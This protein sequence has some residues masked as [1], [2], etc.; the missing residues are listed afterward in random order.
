MVIF[1]RIFWV[2]VTVSLSGGLFYSA[3][4][5]QDIIDWWRLRDYKPSANIVQLS[6]NASFSDL[7][8][9]LFYVHDP[10]LLDKAQFAQSCTVGE[11]T[12]VLGCYITHQRIFVFDVDD[13]RLSGAEEVTAAHE[14][15]HAAYDRLSPDRS[16][17]IDELLIDTFNSLDDPGLKRVV[18]SYRDRDPS[19]VPNELHSILGTEVRDL[20]KLLEEHYAQ[21]FADRSVVVGLAEN[22]S[23]EFERREAEIGVL[24][25]QLE[26]LKSEIARIESDLTLQ[27][28]ALTRD[29]KTLESLVG[30]DP[31]E[32]NRRI[33]AF[34]SRINKYNSD[35]AKAGKLVDRH[36]EIV[37]AR[38]TI[39]LEEK[40]L[41]EAIDT[42]VEEL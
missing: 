36:N 40:E 4:H 27:A 26:S 1:K 22:Y 19:V 39:A 35:V 33:P 21:Y 20:P 24:D 9:K 23:D 37:K 13:E 38:N 34:N 15:L 30:T 7:G 18:E 29:R 8:Q 2:L 14:M 28:S 16:K 31:Q 12:I 3:Y 17:E 6:K 5:S 32:Y 42:R 10:A 41:V 25:K 11:E